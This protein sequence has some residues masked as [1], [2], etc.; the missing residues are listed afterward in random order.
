MYKTF[1][2]LLAAYVNSY[3]GRHAVAAE[4]EEIAVKT[5]QALSSVFS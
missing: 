5:C 4:T 2:G 3:N 1:S